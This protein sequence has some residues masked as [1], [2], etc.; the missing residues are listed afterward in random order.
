MPFL[1]DGEVKVIRVER[2]GAGHKGILLTDGAVRILAVLDEAG[3][4]ELVA[5]LMKPDS[6]DVL[7]VAK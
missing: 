5:D 3:R 6:L 1:F 4:R 7:K 2:D